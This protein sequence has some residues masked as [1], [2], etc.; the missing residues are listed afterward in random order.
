MGKIIIL[1]FL[2]LAAMGADDAFSSYIEYGTSIL[3]V[4]FVIWIISKLISI[5]SIPYKLIR[6]ILSTIPHFGGISKKELHA[7]N[8]SLRTEVD[9]LFNECKANEIA[10]HNLRSKNGFFTTENEDLKEKA[11]RSK[12]ELDKF[13]KDHQWALDIREQFQ[14]IGHENDFLCGTTIPLE[15]RA[16]LLDYKAAC[17]KAGCDPKKLAKEIGQIQKEAISHDEKC[18]LT[19]LKAQHA[20]LQKDHPHTKQWTLE[21]VAE[22]VEF[23]NQTCIITDALPGSLLS[24]VGKLK[25]AAERTK[26]ELE[27]LKAKNAELANTA[28]EAY[29]ELTKANERYANARMEYRKELEVPTHLSAKEFIAGIRANERFHGKIE[30]IVELKN[31][32]GIPEGINL[33]AWLKEEKRKAATLTP[34]GYRQQNTKEILSKISSQEHLLINHKIEKT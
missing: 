2:A 17:E 11:A 15:I 22:L 30:D 10:I 3:A 9:H 16:R 27:E 24:T 34:D 25:C 4:A 20:I 29:S 28:K 5:V 8:K 23:Y 7:D 26:K 18:A 19:R 12:Q 33:T 13:K 32:L 14:D 21:T 6:F 31:S 1:G